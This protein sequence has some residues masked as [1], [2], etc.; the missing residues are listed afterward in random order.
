MLQKN[1]MIIIVVWVER[2]SKQVIHVQR[3]IRCFRVNF[4]SGND[5]AT[6]FVS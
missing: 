6:A 1:R 3:Q 2:R 5:D 4:G